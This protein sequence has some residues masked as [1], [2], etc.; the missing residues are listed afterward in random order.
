MLPFSSSLVYPSTTVVNPSW[1]GVV[2]KTEADSG[3]HNHHQQLPFLDK[4]NMFLGATSPNTNNTSYRAAGNNKSFPILQGHSPMING[5]MAPED[6][7]CHP[8]S[9]AF[10][11]LSQSS[12]A[13]RI[14]VFY[15]RLLTTTTTTTTTQVQ[16][17]DCALSLLSSPQAQ[18]SEMGLGHNIMSQLSS[19]IPL[20]GHPTL[21]AN[22]LEP[23][24]SSVLVSNGNG[25]A[26]VHCP[27]MF[28]MGSDGNEAHQTLPP[29]WEL[30]EKE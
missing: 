18:T 28:N 25:T 24:M 27:G 15:D 21:Q 7:V 4:Q 26:D 2:V 22:G 14:K 16:N 1:G 29:H 5:Q 11:S 13:P 9:R 19:S 3:L 8:L 23:I 10:P 30:Y 17:S 6:S 12:E 20:I